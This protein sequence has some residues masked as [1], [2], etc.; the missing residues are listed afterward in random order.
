MLKSLLNFS[1]V[2]ILGK[3]EQK[4]IAGGTRTPPT[5]TYCTIPW[6][7]FPY[8]GPC[9]MLPQDSPGPFPDPFPEPIEG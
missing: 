3:E 1:K 8:H 4:S 9:M 2:E 7:P 6:T 5:Q